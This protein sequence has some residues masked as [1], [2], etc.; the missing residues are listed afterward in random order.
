MA[1]LPAF[2]VEPKSFANRADFSS[3]VF[4]RCRTAAAELVVMG[5]WLKLVTIPD[6]FAGRVIN[7]GNGAPVTGI[8]ADNFTVRWTGEIERRAQER[9]EEAT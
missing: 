2:V 8:G 7:W 9:E 6:D 5:G 4:D 1:D 3:A